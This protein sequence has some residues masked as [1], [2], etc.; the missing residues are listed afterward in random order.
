[1]LAGPFWGKVE[2]LTSSNQNFYVPTP[3]NYLVKDGKITDK[4]TYYQ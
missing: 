1:M 4:L 3:K 2:E